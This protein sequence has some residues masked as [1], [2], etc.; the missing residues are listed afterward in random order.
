MQKD[1]WPQWLGAEKEVRSAFFPLL[2][3]WEYHNHVEMKH[4]VPYQSYIKQMAIQEYNASFAGVNK[5]DQ[6]RAHY[7]IVNKA[8][9]LWTYVFW[10]LLYI[11]AVNAYMLYRDTPVGPWPKCISHLDLQLEVAKG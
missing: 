4:G 5:S 8:T 6:F 9:K 11:S 10:F 3:D 2:L 1:A 7:G